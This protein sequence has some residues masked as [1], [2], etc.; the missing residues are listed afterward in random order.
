VISEIARHRDHHAQR[1]DV[2]RAIEKRDFPDPDRLSGRHLHQYLVLRG[3]LR[4]EEGRVDWCDEVLEAMR[5][6]Q[7]RKPD[8][9]DNR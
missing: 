2:Y 1:L 5:R 6:D 3:G 8:E 7:S 4:V 9:S